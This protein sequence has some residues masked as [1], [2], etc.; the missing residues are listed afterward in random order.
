[1]NDQSEPRVQKVRGRAAA[2]IAVG[3]AAHQLL[4]PSPSAMTLRQLFY[5]LVSAEAI[6]K[7]EAAYSKLKRVI[8][9]LR[10]AGVIP[11]EWIVDHTRSVFRSSAWGG[12]E[13]VLANAART[14]RRQLMREQPV[15]MQ[16]WAESDRIG[17]VAA[18]VAEEFTIPTYIGRGYSARGYLWEAARDTVQAKKAGKRVVIFHVGDYDPSGE[19]IYRDVEETL[20]L[21]AL[22]LDWSSNL[23]PGTRGGSAKA[24]RGS[25]QR[26]LRIHGGSLLDELRGWTK[27]LTFERLA[28]TPD[29]ISEFGLPGRPP[30]ASDPRT[31]GFTGSGTVEVEALPVDA[32]LALVKVAI[33]H[34]ID[35]RALQVVKV[36]EA[37]ER[38]VLVRIA[39]TPLER[40]VAAS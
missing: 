7:S 38:D 18:Q 24:V 31:S 14:Y 29:Q 5:A 1:M 10:E 27:W 20:R 32:L 36:A 13:E 19:D 33:E 39:R 4:E 37:S 8:R 3:E 9:D 16:L 25:L 11:W 30:K 40:L 26:D 17:S 12:P 6:P 35:A 23:L 21:Y 28:L 34:Y 22:T 2:T 15:A